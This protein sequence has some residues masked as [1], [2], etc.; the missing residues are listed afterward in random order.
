M[1]KRLILETLISLHKKVD[2]NAL[3]D[4]QWRE[5][6]KERQRLERELAGRSRRELCQR[7]IDSKY[8]KNN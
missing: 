7:K 2:V 1:S 8:S 5:Y 3:S 4:D 6:Q